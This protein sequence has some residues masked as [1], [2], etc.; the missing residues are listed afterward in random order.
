VVFDPAAMGNAA[1]VL[2]D[3]VTYAASAE[4]CAG[5]SD[6]LAV[7]TAWKDF[8]TIRPAHLKRG[9]RKPVILDCWRVIDVKA[10]ENAAVMLTLGAAPCPESAPELTQTEHA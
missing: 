4:E 10:F 2:G 3:G 5:Q 1:R 8:Q 6:V 9:K 7:T